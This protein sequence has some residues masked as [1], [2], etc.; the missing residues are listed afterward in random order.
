MIG[1]YAHLGRYRQLLQ[2]K[3]FYLVSAGSLLILT[4]YVLE[5]NNYPVQADIPALLALALLG[6]PIIYGAC[7]G[8]LNRELNVDELVS[9]AMVASVLIGEYLAAA[10]VALIMVLGSLMEQYT[11]QKARSAIDALIRISPRQATVLRDGVEVSVPVEEIRPGDMVVVRSGDRVP[12]DGEVVRGSASLSQA[13]LTGESM[14]VDKTVGDTVY[15]GSVSYSG[16]VVVEAR[17]VGEDTTL[18]KLIQL[19]R[20]AESQRAPVLRVA[21][22]FAGYFTPTIIAIGIAV[23]L[24]TGDVHR[25]IT[26]LIVGCPCAFIISAPTAIV[27]ALG[28]ASK[29]GVLIKG[30]ALLEELAR[31][32]TLVFDKTGTL[33]TGNP[34]VA[35][36]VPLSGAVEERVLALAAAAEKYSGHPLARAVLSAAEQ[37]GLAIAEPEDFKNIPGQGVEAVVD[38]RKIFV[39]AASPGNGAIEGVQSEP[40]VKTLLVRENGLIIGA[41]YIKDSIRAGTGVLIKSLAGSGLKRV[42]ML[43]GD[44]YPV[45]AHVAKACGIR[46]FWAGLLPEQKLDHIWELQRSG[47]KVAMVGDGINDAPA[48]AAAD[49]GIAMGAMGTDVA[50]EA[51]DIA[52]ME[53]NLAKMPYLLQLGR[54]TLKTINFNIAFAVLFNLLALAASGAGLLNPVT[55]AVAHN[56]GS[57]LVVLNSARLIGFAGRN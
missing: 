1:R 35:G 22:R 29:N 28:N 2:M 4:S 3:E 56:A 39:G 11:A 10:V 27:A 25:S 40:G 30:G 15:A 32:D 50:M 19:V 23:Y 48:L 37:R 43:T 21:D 54:A 49:I 36:V 53:D 31:I 42:Q 41:I 18:G 12:V 57:V 20:D 26:V 17:K 52:L 8:L 7:K 46:E 5:K 55:G 33:T 45:A 34:V 9:L 47:H 24:V 38:G 44:E 16:M 14:P 51:A 6:G 13:S